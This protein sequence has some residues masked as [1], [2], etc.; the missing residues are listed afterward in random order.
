MPSGSPEA[1]TWTAPQKHSPLCVA[2]ALTSSTSSAKATPSLSVL[3]DR[4]PVARGT[5]LLEAECRESTLDPSIGRARHTTPGFS[6]ILASARGF[7]RAR[8]EAPRRAV[9]TREI[10]GMTA[11]E[12]AA[13]EAGQDFIRDIVRADLD[14]GRTKTVV[15]RFPPEPNG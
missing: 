14:A 3:P 11:V 7:A 13:R 9:P 5:R 6:A 12:T 15:T 4:T 10:E 8:I 2:I 1:S